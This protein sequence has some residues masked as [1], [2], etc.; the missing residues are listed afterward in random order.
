[1]VADRERELAEASSYFF[2]KHYAHRPMRKA[3]GA[4]HQTLAYLRL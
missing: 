1:V 4:V 3:F 2:A